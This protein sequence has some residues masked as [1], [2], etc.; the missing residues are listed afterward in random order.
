MFINV[1]GNES[2]VADIVFEILADQILCIVFRI[3][4]LLITL[5]LD[6]RFEFKIVSF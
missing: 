2:Y 3:D 4:K 1:K 5:K 6:I